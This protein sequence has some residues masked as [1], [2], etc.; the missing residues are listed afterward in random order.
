MHPLEA[1]HEDHRAFKVR[2]D[3]MEARL[4]AAMNARQLAPEA[5]EAFRADLGFMRGPM[6]NH[7]RTEDEVLLPAVERRIG[8]FGDSLV[9]ILWQEHRELRR[10][11]DKFDEALTAMATRPGDQAVDELNRYGLFFVQV[12]QDH[13]RKEETAFFETARKSLSPEDWAGVEAQMQAR[14]DTTR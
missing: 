3:A 12:L 6:L 2:F 1:L 4:D 8:R 7:F 5:L 14:R 9:E 13:I 10:A 11:A